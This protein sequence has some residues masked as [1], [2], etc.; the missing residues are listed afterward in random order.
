M[1]V[2]SS[3]RMFLLSRSLWAVSISFLL[4][5]MLLVH[6]SPA[7]VEKLSGLRASSIV[8]WCVNH[9][10]LFYFFVMG[11]FV[12]MIYVD[13]KYPEDTRRASLNIS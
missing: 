12:F 9:G 3:A 10:Y 13:Q 11:S 2:N 7:P 8:N 5:R 4:I 6:I 1:S